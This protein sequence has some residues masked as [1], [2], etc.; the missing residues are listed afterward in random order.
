[1]GP[2]WVWLGSLEAN[3]DPRCCGR[4]RQQKLS[5]GCRPRDLSG[6]LGLPFKICP[7]C[8]RNQVEDRPTGVEEWCSECEERALRTY[9][10]VDYQRGVLPNGITNFQKK[11]CL[12]AAD[13]LQ[14]QGAALA[15][16]DEW[17]KKL[18]NNPD[19]NEAKRVLLR[20]VAGPFGSRVQRVIDR[21]TKVDLLHP[22][23]RMRG[24]SKDEEEQAIS[25]GARPGRG[26][27]E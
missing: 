22:I 14:E 13:V 18:Q 6:A 20:E 16:R 8:Q 23:N 2:E 26:L 9:Y 3:D 21:M 19:L 24:Q 1:M 15:W 5:C 7:A 25:F 12:H 11:Q 17:R 27:S 4:R 10:H